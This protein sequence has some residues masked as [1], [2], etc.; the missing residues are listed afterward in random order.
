[1]RVGIVGYGNL[2]K[3]VEAAVNVAEDMELVCVVT[4]RN[5]ETLKIN[6]TCSGRCTRTSGFAIDAR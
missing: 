1:M 3:G 5:P 6:S 4:R 2:G